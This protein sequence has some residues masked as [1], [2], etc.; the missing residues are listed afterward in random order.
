MCL[1]RLLTITILGS[2]CCSILG[3]HDLVAIQ[4]LDPTLLVDIRYATTNNFTHTAVYSRPAAYLVQ[5]AAQ[6]LIAANKELQQRG[7]RIK[8]WDSY[9]PQA[10]Q[11]KFWSLMP[12]ERYVSNPRKGSKHSRGCAVDCTLV[13]TAG[14]EIDMGSNFDDFSERAH[15]D[16]RQLTPQQRTN[17]ALLRETMARHGFTVLRSEWWHFDYNCWQQYPLLDIPFE[18]LS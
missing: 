7:Y 6:A 1:Q 15:S 8:I 14:K 13:D 11:Y 16:Y 2:Q 10:V 5:A 12:N 9:R 3:R 18:K 4:K 17:R